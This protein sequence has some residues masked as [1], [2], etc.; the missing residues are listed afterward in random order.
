MTVVRKNSIIVSFIPL[1][2]VVLLYADRASACSCIYH[3]T[4]QE[5]LQRSSSVFAGTVLSIS[6]TATS[7]VGSTDA[8]AVRFGVS[9]V[10][11]G[12]QRSV[13]TVHIGQGGGDCGYPFV[14]GKQYL[15]YTYE[16]MGTQY[17][18]TC[19]RTAELASAATDLAALGPGTGDLKG[20]MASFTVNTIA[21]AT[22]SSLVVIFLALYQQRKKSR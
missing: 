12:D 6:R 9:S 2:L 15:V 4:P 17:A 13:L 10:W 21:T 14:V 20:S 11:K 22:A 8:K 18:I 3:G 19:S 16:S 5:E 7:Y 1:L